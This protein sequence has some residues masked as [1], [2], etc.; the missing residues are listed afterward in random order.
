MRSIR[1]VG[2]T[3]TLV[4]AMLGTLFT[5][6]ASATVKGDVANSSGNLV[7][8]ASGG[9][10][11]ASGGFAVFN[12]PPGNYYFSGKVACYWQS[13]DLTSATFVATITK[14]QDETGELYTFWLVDGKANNPDAYSYDEGGVCTDTYLRATPLVTPVV[15]GGDLSIR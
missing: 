14:P 4:V 6:V 7:F 1:A 8:H 5:G 15:A 13:A 3:T 2:V 10:K 9:T 12:A 11:K